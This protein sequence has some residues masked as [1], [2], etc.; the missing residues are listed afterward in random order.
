MKTDIET[1]YERTFLVCIA[2]ALAL[3]VSGCS[4]HPLKGG[5]ALTA[6]PLAQSVSQGENAAQPTRQTQ[7][8][9]R[10]YSFPAPILQSG[11]EAGTPLP[12]QTGRGASSLAPIQHPAPIQYPVLAPPEL[13]S[14]GGSRIQYPATIQIREE[15]HA[16]TELG[17]AQKDTAR[18]LGAKL[19]SLKPI[20]WVGL[21]LFVF[22][23]TSLFWPP[24][25]AIIGSVT[26]SAA[27]AA[28]GLTLIILP[29][30]IVGNELPIL[31][32]VGIVIAA[33]FLAHRHGHVR[34]QL[35]TLTGK[36]PTSQ[37]R[38]GN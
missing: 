30:L 9:I 33:W 38:F 19:T 22:G 14:G 25:K 15:S 11:A 37:P 24:L 34:G 29:T 21:A 10:T 16:A 23:L 27:I 8:F 31:G 5:R 2:V 17:A 6:G 4:S 7:D 28:G 32:G 3:G 20:V 12:T 13:L 36:R 26:T 18:E 1:G 35:H